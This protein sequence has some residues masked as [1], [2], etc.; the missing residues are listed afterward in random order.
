MVLFPPGLVLL[1][2]SQV[3]TYKAVE[4]VNGSVNGASKDGLRRGSSGNRG[5]EG[6]KAAKVLIKTAY[7]QS[8]F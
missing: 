1:A 8:C 5:I 6:A 2:L 4:E 7:F 3:K